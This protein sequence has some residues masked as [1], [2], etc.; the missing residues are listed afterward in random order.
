MPAGHYPHRS[1]TIQV[2]RFLIHKLE[3]GT[4]EAQL[5]L[6]FAQSSCATLCNSALW[7]SPWPHH[8]SDLSQQYGPTTTHHTIICRQ[9]G[10]L[11]MIPYVLSHNR[12]VSSKS[13]S[14][15]VISE[16]CVESGSCTF[17]LPYRLRFTVTSQRANLKEAIGLESPEPLDVAAEE[18]T[19]C[20]CCITIDSSAQS[21]PSVVGFVL[22]YARTYTYHNPYT[23][24]R[25]SKQI[26]QCKGGMVR[27]YPVLYGDSSRNH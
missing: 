7:L 15:V 21:I 11:K 25:N 6:L 22:G 14:C 1:R 17:A 8:I 18:H 20:S 27:A 5:V 23:T 12:Q 10:L 4:N 9:H 13:G 3:A 19:R 2:G 26:V 16:N 24:Y